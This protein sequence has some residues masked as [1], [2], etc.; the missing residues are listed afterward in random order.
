MFACDR[1]ILDCNVKSFPAPEVVLA[2]HV[3]RRA[4]A[5]VVVLASTSRRLEPGVLPEL[6]G[7][8]FEAQ[9]G[10]E[11][12]RRARHVRHC[13]VAA[14]QRRGHVN[15]PAFVVIQQ[16]EQR[17]PALSPHVPWNTVAIHALSLSLFRSL[18]GDINNGTYEKI[19][20]ALRKNEAW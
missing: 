19:L 16:R 18:H 5:G 9:R 17:V 10:V 13:E 15:A 8:G 12:L 7:H 11:V 2:E 20:C 4:V 6:G 1:H 3:G 14:A